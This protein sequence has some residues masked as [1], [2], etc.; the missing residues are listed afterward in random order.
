MFALTTD[1]GRGGGVTI[2]IVPPPH[3]VKPAKER[4]KPGTTS[5][6]IRHIVAKRSQPE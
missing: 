4:N 3:A 6:F 1:G 2:A 5:F